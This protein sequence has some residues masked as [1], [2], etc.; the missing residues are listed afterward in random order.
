MTDQRSLLSNT[1]CFFVRAHSA[2]MHVGGGNPAFV[3]MLQVNL[4]PRVH[5]GR[6]R[7]K[8]FW[9]I[10][11][12]RYELTFPAVSMFV[13]SAREGEKGGA[14]RG[15]KGVNVRTNQKPGRAQI[16]HDAKPGGEKKLNIYILFFVK[17]FYS[18]F[19]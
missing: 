9:C 18:A 15:R 6:L 19:I 10:L 14:V 7:F 11:W 17:L 16:T 12:G 5:D 1:Q 8:C 4:T 13:P 2:D 3:L